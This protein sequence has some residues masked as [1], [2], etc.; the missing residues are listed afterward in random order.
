MLELV[1]Y[2]L[3]FCVCVT[4]EAACLCVVHVCYTSITCVLHVYY[5]CVKCE[6]GLCAPALCAPVCTSALGTL[7]RAEDGVW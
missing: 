7:P 3:P 4:W 1:A 5:M 2:C 6:A